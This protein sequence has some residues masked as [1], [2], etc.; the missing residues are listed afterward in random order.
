MTETIDYTQKFREHA[1]HMQEMTT[2][3]ESIFL[4]YLKVAEIGPMYFRHW[5]LYNE[6]I[7]IT[8]GDTWLSIPL[9]FFTDSDAAFA[10]LAHDIESQKARR[11]ERTRQRIADAQSIRN[12]LRGLAL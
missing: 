3:V 8:D 4:R 6:A 5:E 10:E 12:G 7:A 9:R 2:Y 11:E 1:Q